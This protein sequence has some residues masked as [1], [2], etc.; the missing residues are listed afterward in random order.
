MAKVKIEEVERK[1]L[2]QK[3]QEMKQ[4]VSSLAEDVRKLF[5]NVFS[6]EDHSKVRIR[7]H[8]AS[9]F[10]VGEVFTVKFIIDFDE[11]LSLHSLSYNFDIESKVSE[12]DFESFLVSFEEKN[13]DYIFK[14]L[15]KGKNCY[16]KLNSDNINVDRFTKKMG[17]ETTLLYLNELREAVPAL[18]AASQKIKD[19]KK[20]VV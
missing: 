20:R 6:T 12:D 16:L 2:Y 5:A 17:L 18:E 9:P 19:L 10:Y 3:A 15:A 1:R 14:H 4:A 8:V 11:K 7:T 13:A